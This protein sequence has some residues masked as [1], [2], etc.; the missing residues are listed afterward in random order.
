MAKK[1]T[2]AAVAINTPLNEALL[3]QDKVS[4]ATLTVIER[5]KAISNDQAATEGNTR[6]DKAT[7]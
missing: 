7:A 2:P 3:A 5:S 4:L 6:Q 1:P